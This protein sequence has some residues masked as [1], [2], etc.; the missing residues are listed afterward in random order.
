MDLSRLLE[1]MTEKVKSHPHPVW[2]F[3]FNITGIGMEAHTIVPIRC[4]KKVGS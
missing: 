3:R 4:F 1:P 2:D